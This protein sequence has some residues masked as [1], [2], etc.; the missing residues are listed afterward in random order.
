MTTPGIQTPAHAELRRFIDHVPALGWSALP[1]GS[2]EYVN[3]RFRD[4]TGLS[5]DELYG[6][7]WKS[8]IHRDDIQPLESWSQ[9]LLQSRDDIPLLA[10]YF[11]QKFAKQMQKRI[12]SI[13]VA[14][15]KALTAWEWPGNIRELENFIE[16][17]VILTRG[18]SLAAPLAELRKVTTD[19]PVRESAPKADDDIARIVKETIASLKSDAAPNERSK[20]QHDEIVRVLT[21]CKG[22]VGGPTAPQCVWV[23]AAQ[24]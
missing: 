8:A 16:R 22:R 15:M 20:K 4:Y 2:L 14:T 9:E 23:S 6:S 1:D 5:P 18:E 19:E 13:P 3:Q 17:A 21:E 24:R 12:D 7:G 10:V 11:V